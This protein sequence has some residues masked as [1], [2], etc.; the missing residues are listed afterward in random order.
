MLP[1]WILPPLGEEHSVAEWTLALTGA[2]SAWLTVNPELGSVGSL[3]WKRRFPAGSSIPI[4]TVIHKHTRP[5]PTNSLKMNQ[6][7]FFKLYVSWPC[8]FVPLGQIDVFLK[9]L[10]V[11]SRPHSCFLSNRMFLLIASHHFFSHLT[12]I[13][14][15]KKLKWCH[16]VFKSKGPL[17][18]GCW[19]AVSCKHL[20]LKVT[21]LTIE[22]REVD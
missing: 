1:V 14:Y 4:W 2:T 22:I 21:D 5:Q 11:R 15:T 20:A 6:L 18:F 13:V 19:F 3:E 7:Y 17:L 8:V 10:K 12:V 16:D 9:P